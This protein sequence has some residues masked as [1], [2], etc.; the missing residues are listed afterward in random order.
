MEGGGRIDGH[1]DQSAKLT[2]A[3]IDM[4]HIVAHLKLLNLLQRQCHLSTSCLIGA[5][6]VLMETVEYLVVGKDTE[7]LVVI[8]KPLMQ[9]LLDGFEFTLS[10]SAK[11]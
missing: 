9:R 3:V 5:Q 6:V 8:R 11:I 2:D 1:S 10:F 4:Y 7:F